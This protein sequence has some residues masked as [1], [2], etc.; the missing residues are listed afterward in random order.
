MKTAGNKSGTKRIDVKKT[1]EQQVNRK[2]QGKQMLKKPVCNCFTVEPRI[3]G[4]QGT[5]EY[6]Q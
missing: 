3:N 5:N 4:C 6:Y 1:T 2:Y